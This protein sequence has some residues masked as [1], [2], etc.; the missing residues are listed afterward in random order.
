[1]NGKIH[2]YAGGTTSAHGSLFLAGEAGPELV[3]S[4]DGQSAV[5]NMEQIIAAISQSVAAAS[6][7]NITVQAV[8]DG[9]V[10]D[11]RIVTAQQRQSL[12]SGR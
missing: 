1:M 7:G 12:R 10:I 9:D 4:Y 6:G 5:M 3:T 2:A 11:E 8:F